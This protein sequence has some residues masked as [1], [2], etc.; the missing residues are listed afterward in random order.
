[1]PTLRLLLSALALAVV[2]E[3]CTDVFDPGSVAGTY[4]LRTVNDAPVPLPGVYAP[5]SGT[6]TLTTPS[7]AARHIR[8][9]VDAG[10]RVRE[11]VLAGTFRLRG[12]TLV[13]ALTEGDQVWRPWAQLIGRTITLRYP[14]AAD[15]PDIVEVYERQ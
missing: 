2:T 7:I 14:D 6:I 3:A 5:L 1:M 8:Y 10:G 9:R 12:S 15:G 4:T 13:L 11:F